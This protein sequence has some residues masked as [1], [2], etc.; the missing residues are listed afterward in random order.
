MEIILIGGPFNRKILD[1]RPD[2][3]LL[4]LCKP[5]TRQ[6]S[7]FYNPNHPV[8]KNRFPT[9]DY[10]KTPATIEGYVAFKIK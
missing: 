8:E 4:S 9:Y 3:I 2:T 5:V 6:D 10:E 1:V 7:I